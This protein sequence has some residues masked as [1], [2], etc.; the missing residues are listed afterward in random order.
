MDRGVL[1]ENSEFFRGLIENDTTAIEVDN[2][3]LF[4]D[5][6]Q[7]IEFNEKDLMR[8]IMKN[9]V[10][11]TIDLLEVMCTIKYERGITSCL[12]YIEAAPWTEN[13][14]EKLKI[15]FSKIKLERPIVNDIVL[16]L[17][18][19]ADFASSA[20][21]DL[22]VHLIRQIANSSNSSARK[23]MQSLVNS[24]LCESSVYQKDHTRINRDSLYQLCN[25][26]LSSLKDLFKE[27]TSV[28]TKPLI[29]RVSSQVE[30]L[31]WLFKIL[32]NNNMAEEF[33]DLWGNQEELVKSHERYSPMV[34][35]ELSRVSVCVFIALGKGKLQCKGEVR[36]QV[37]NSWF[38]P[39]LLDFGWL[40][41]CPKGLDFRMFEE[42]LGRALLTLPLVQQQRLFE[43]WFSFF[44][45]RGTECPNLSAAF[46]VWW[47]RSF[48]RSV[49]MQVG[50]NVV[51]SI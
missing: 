4:R 9:G 35:Y 41:R 24:I 45:V 12:K 17:N 6:I 40:K 3:D 42:T 37:F 50:D 46:Q 8:S 20:E 15:L 49:R 33:V 43:E 31:T 7:L 16:R 51:S 29:E 27:E 21:G 5:A 30:N 32:I 44:S 26:C 18:Q 38:R 1:C 11:H 22:A 2:V 39:I 19:K 14:E 36:L 23:D 48:V 10:S 28:G 25:S 47:R 13:E 34:R